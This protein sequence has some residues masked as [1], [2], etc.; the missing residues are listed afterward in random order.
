MLRFER[1]R[2]EATILAPVRDDTFETAEAYGARIEESC[3]RTEESKRV[4]DRVPWGEPN[5]LPRSDSPTRYRCEN[6]ATSTAREIERKFLIKELPPGL[7]RFRSYSIAQGYLANEMGGRHVR[8]RKRGKTASLTFKLGRGTNR[9][10]RE[11][12]LSSQQ[13]AALWPATAG[14]R[15]RKARYYV[16]WKGL[17]IEIDIYRGRNK[18]LVVAEVEFTSQAACRKFKA[19]VWFGAEVTGVKRYSNVR[20]ARE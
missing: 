6:M 20:L 19:P 9:E 11:I 4:I 14:R 17:T 10:E 12:K 7:E 5:L 1:S 13:F 3:L 2:V 16:P 8:L 15:L 18:G